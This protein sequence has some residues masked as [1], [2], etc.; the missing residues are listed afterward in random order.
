MLIIYSI[1]LVLK[2]DKTFFG[3]NKIS[4]IFFTEFLFSIFGESKITL[5]PTMIP[6]FR[7]SELLSS[8][9]AKG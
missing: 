3:E 9:A 5:A 8:I 4:V 6:F 2:F 7:L 1:T